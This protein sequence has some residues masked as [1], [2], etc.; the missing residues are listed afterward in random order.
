LTTPT[1]LPQGLRMGLGL[2]LE[3]RLRGMV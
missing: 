3:L 1:S 2:V